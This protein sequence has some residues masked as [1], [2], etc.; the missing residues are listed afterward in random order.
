MT[1]TPKFKQSALRKMRERAYAADDEVRA[2]SEREAVKRAMRDDID[3]IVR[4]QNKKV[5]QLAVETADRMGIT[6]WDLCAQY[7]P[8]YSV[9]SI[10]ASANGCT[11]E[12]DITLVGTPPI[13]DD[14][15][16]YESK[17]RDLKERLEEILKDEDRSTAGDDF[18]NFMKGE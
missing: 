13:I 18:K 9:A 7:L 2:A 5:N 12:Q 17:Y 4:E 10:S 11:W 8:H 1:T 15:V 14:G 6:V 3:L 16:D